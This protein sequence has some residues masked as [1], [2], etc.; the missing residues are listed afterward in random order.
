[1]S[2]DVNNVNNDDDV[3]VDEE[4]VDDDDDD[5]DDDGDVRRSQWRTELLL[6]R[7]E[8]LFLR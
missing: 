6:F 7:T 2:I 4:V 3:D 1:M 5:D 8:L